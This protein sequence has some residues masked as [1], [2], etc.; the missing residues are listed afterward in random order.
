MG[1][2]H[3]SSLR[4]AIET[5]GAFEGIEGI[6]I[7][8]SDQPLVTADALN[9]ILETH[10][11][12]GKDIVASEY[13]DTHGVPL[14][15]GKLFFDE[16]A[17]SNG[18]QGAKARDRTSHRGDDDGA[19]CGGG[20]RRRH[21]GRLRAAHAFE[22]QVK[23]GPWTAWTPRAGHRSDGLHRSASDRVSSGRTVARRAS[24]RAAR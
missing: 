19:A 11:E 24:T 3:G 15:I 13:A 20:V 5:L 10:D 6:V 22:P 17:A 18:N 23:R 21:S 2:R 7:A 9:R 12:T 16:I 14:F 1:K 4:L 8:L